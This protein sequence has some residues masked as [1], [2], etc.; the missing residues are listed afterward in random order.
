LKGIL[1]YR[2]P[3]I[4]SRLTVTVTVLQTGT[5]TPSMAAGANSHFALPRAVR[6]APGASKR[7]EK[8]DVIQGL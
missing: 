5:G 2:L 8:D 6:I 1:A 3:L 4:A 7:V